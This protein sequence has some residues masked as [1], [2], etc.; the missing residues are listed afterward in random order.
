MLEHDEQPFQRI[1]PPNPTMPP[2]TRQTTYS[3]LPPSPRYEQYDFAETKI[4]GK[5]FEEAL[6]RLVNGDGK[7]KGRI[8]SL[9]VPAYVD[10]NQ[11]GMT[12]GRGQVKVEKE[13]EEIN[14][15]G[16]SMWDL[17]RDEVGVEDWDGWI[18]DGKW[19]RIANFLAVPL[20][21]EK[22]CLPYPPNY[23]IKVDMLGNSIR[24]SPLPRWIPIQFHN[25]PYPINL[26]NSSNYLQRH[27]SKTY[28]PYTPYSFIINL[29]DVTTL[30]P[31]RCLATRYGC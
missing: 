13:N 9:N 7:E 16:L 24:S 14:E 31:N 30:H 10:L 3:S 22:V 5:E 2:L 28:P 21:V 4:K 23:R 20:A 26:C 6:G 25:P 15:E 8:L 19:E 29:E 18:V 1:A 12:E 27:S 11:S 17:L